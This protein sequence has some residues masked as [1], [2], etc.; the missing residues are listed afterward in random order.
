[1]GTNRYLEKIAGQPAPPS[2]LVSKIGLGVSSVGL[3]VSGANFFNNR[4]ATG[5]ELKRLQLEAE[6]NKLEQKSLTALKS[7]HKTLNPPLQKTASASGRPEKYQGEKGDLYTLGAVSGVGGAKVLH[8][9]LAK[10]NLTGRETLWH[11]TS[12]DRAESIRK[13]GLQPNR[14][15]VSVFV[16]PDLHQANKDLTFLAKSKLSA[17][18]YAAQQKHLSNGTV[19]SLEQLHAWQQSPKAIRQ[20]ALHALTGE[21]V[22]KVNLPTWKPEFKGVRNPELDMISNLQK[23]FN[24]NI[25]KALGEQS[26]HVVSGSNGIPTEYI[27]GSK[28]YS[29]AGISEILDFAKHN[30]TRF[31]KGLGAAAVGLGGVGLGGALINKA[32]HLQKLRHNPDD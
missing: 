18:S 14:E 17:G 21:G 4:A 28:N 6:R 5:L 29:R 26:V 2:S 8:H 10:G 11:G 25:T 23:A 12:A 24:P 27:K 30:K 13:N 22:V 15:G 16:N 9:Q 32:N 19:S 20:S 7:I 3:G 31:A 1:M